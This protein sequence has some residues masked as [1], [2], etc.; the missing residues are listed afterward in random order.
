MSSLRRAEFQDAAV[1]LI[2]DS[3]QDRSG[4]RRF[5]LAD[6]VG[7]GKTIVARGVIEALLGRRRKPLV[8][9]YLCSNV[10]IADQ[11]RRKLD[12]DAGRPL[13]RVT[14]LAYGARP[15]GNLHLY[16]FT[17][18]TSLQEGTGLAW[19]R[20]LL[21]FLVFRVLRKDVRKGKWREY[22]QCGA[23]HETWTTETRFRGPY[24]EFNRKLSAS[25]QQLVGKEWRKPAVRPN[26]SFYPS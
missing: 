26:V 3:L 13:R 6:E 20:R 18:G 15:Q 22:F 14:E 8:V 11:N 10:E 5:L 7:L 4:S 17:P 24:R 21:L 9:V 19:E 23:G 25:F 1:R 12:P 16:S 2:A